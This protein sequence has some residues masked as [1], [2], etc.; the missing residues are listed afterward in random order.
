MHGKLVWAGNL[1]LDYVAAAIGEA[2]H[3]GRATR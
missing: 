3:R 2:L 1:V